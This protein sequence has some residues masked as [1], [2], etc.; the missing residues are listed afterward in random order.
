MKHRLEGLKIRMNIVQNIITQHQKKLK[1]QQNG[2]NLCLKILECNDGLCAYQNQ[3]YWTNEVAKFEKHITQNKINVEEHIESV[4][5][6][7]AL[8]R[9]QL[10]SNIL[11]LEQSI[12]NM[13]LTL[14]KQHPKIMQN[15][16]NIVN[17]NQMINPE[18]VQN[19]QNSLL[20]KQ[21]Y[22]NAL[23]E[24]VL[25]LKNQMHEFEH[26]DKFSSDE[27]DCEIRRFEGNIKAYEQKLGIPQEFTSHLH[28]IKYQS[29]AK[30]RSQS[31]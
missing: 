26:T 27:A 18:K 25:Q 20:Q 23:Q 4:E 16:V 22:I 3:L 11:N 10:Q 17:G 19:F 7:T 30:T 8:N 29:N 31:L 9:Q 5:I 13:R 28:Y 14:Y 2:I 6:L 21:N 1:F 15:V 24:R 12:N